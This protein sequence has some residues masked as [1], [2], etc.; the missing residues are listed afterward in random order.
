MS[1]NGARRR[2][3]KPRDT[4]RVHC[5][6]EAQQSREQA[7]QEA[8]EA[9]VA[10]AAPSLRKAWDRNRFCDISARSTHPTGDGD[11]WKHGFYI[12]RFVNLDQETEA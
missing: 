5:S 12:D 1:R 11:Q 2:A 8:Y 7:C 9:P 4:I 10:A 3:Q 6:P